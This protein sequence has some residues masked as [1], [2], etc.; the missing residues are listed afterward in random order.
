MLLSPHQ[1]AGKNHDIKT[2]NRLFENVAQF[3]YSGT[4]G[5]NK[6]LIQGK[7]RGD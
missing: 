3:T 1:Y 4:T 7:L 2:A 5:T 6:T